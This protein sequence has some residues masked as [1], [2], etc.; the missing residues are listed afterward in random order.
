V[1]G[2]RD[3]TRLLR[4]AVHRV[5]LS[6]ARLPIREDAYVVAIEG[7]L[8]EESG[9]LEYLLLRREG[10][11]TGV[12]TEVLIKCSLRLRDTLFALLLHPEL[13]SKLISHSDYLLCI[14]RL[15]CC[16]QRAHTAVNTDFPLHVLQHI[17]QSL[18]LNDL[19]HEFDLHFLMFNLEV[20]D[21]RGEQDLALL[22]HL[23]QFIML[24]LQCLIPLLQSR[25]LFEVLY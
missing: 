10:T 4:R 18:P 25:V 23:S 7:T 6:T 14:P 16:V 8:E 19:V 22:V 12:E 13:E 3:Q 24:S 2:S 21:L 9:V 1:Q 5:G 20:L 17:M 11:E 15:L